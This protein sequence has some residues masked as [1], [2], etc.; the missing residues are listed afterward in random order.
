MSASVTCPKCGESISVYRNPVP[1]VDVVIYAPGRG[2]VLVERAN[3]PYGWALPGGFVDYGESCEHAAIREAKEETG[4]DVELT[5]IVGVYSDPDRDPRQHTMSVVYS[6][7]APDP[8]QLSAGDDA[9][10]ACFF[11]RSALPELVFD[12]HKILTDFFRAIV[13]L[14]IK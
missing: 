6:A 1:T 12:H 10:K 3:P 8:E 11:A 5:G 14:N 13:A 9:A 2:V 4:L 7:Q